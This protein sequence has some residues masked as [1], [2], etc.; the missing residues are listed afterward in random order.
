MSKNEAICCQAWI[1]FWEKA[2]ELM[3]DLQFEVSRTLH[4]GEQTSQR[5]DIVELLGTKPRPRVFLYITSFK[6]YKDV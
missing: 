3:G 1:P 6:T 5:A 2:G 4:V